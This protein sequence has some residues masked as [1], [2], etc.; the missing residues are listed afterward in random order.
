[1]RRYDK[2]LKAVERIYREINFTR[3]NWS[4]NGGDAS[5]STMIIAEMIAAQWKVYGMP[6]RPRRENRFLYPATVCGTEN[7]RVRI[8]LAECRLEPLQKDDAFY[9]YLPTGAP[10]PESVI[11]PDDYGDVDLKQEYM[12]SGDL[13]I[14]VFCGEVERRCRIGLAELQNEELNACAEINMTQ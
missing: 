6:I 3:L 7:K 10:Y 14:T 9:Q 8:C 4:L 2:Y 12:L 1:M 11:F 5:Y 13:I